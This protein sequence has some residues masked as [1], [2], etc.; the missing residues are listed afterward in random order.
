MLLDLPVTLNYN[1]NYKDRRKIKIRS[2][3]MLK[4]LFKLSA[5]GAILAS[6]TAFVIDEILASIA[7][8]ESLSVVM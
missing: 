7:I 6:I 2:F 3:V 1:S 8:F 5:I 4:G